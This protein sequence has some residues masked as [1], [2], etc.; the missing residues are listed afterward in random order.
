MKYLFSMISTYHWNNRVLVLWWLR[1]VTTK[2]LGIAV[3]ESQSLG[4]H[5]GVPRAQSQG[6]GYLFPVENKT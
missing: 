3:G 6:P 4:E 1:V 2:L 5:N